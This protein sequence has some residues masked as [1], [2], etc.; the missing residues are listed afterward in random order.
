MLLRRNFYSKI[1][2]IFVFIL[3]LVFLFGKTSS[4]RK[5]KVSVNK[6]SD[7]EISLEASAIRNERLVAADSDNSIYASK[8]YHLKGWIDRDLMKQVPGL[9]EEGRIANLEGSA[10]EIGEKQ[11]TKIALNEELSEH[12]SYN[13]SVPDARNPACRKKRFDMDGLAGFPTSVIIIFFNEPYSVLVRTVHSV[14]NT[15]T[16]GR[17]L[18]EV[19]LVDDA[20]TNVE[21]K[22]KLDYYITN[23]LPKKVKMLRLKNR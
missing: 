11:L 2:L 20:S 3:V 19:I 21:L 17:L 16:D 1:I 12:I 13:R 10:K 7:V 8:D 4:N 6:I 15:V 14:L 22:D 18:K 9:G 23:M 5:N